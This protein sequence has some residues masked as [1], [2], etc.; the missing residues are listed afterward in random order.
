[1]T[2]LSGPLGLESDFNQVVELT[3]E[4]DVGGEKIACM[5]H[6]LAGVYNDPEARKAIEQALRQAL[7]M[8]ILKKWSPVIKVRRR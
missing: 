7:M 4:A 1:M 6:C 2:R 8:Q 5:Q 3:V